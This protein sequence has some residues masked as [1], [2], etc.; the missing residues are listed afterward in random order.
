MTMKETFRQQLADAIG[1]KYIDRIVKQVVETPSCFANLYAL[2]KDEDETTAW[3]A[4]WACEKLS[5]CCPGLFIAPEDLRGEL[6]LRARSCLHGGI[7]RLLLNL[8][9]HLPVSVPIDVPFLN[10]CLGNMLSPSETPAGQAAS[11]KLAYA[12][13]SK[14]PELLEELRLCLENMEPE[15]YTAAV[16]CARNNVLKKL[17]KHIGSPSRETIT[18]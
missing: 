7:R 13:C 11:I 5:I 4:A 9:L 12:L 6:M 15:Y 3:H 1:R 8:L 14:E 10:F 17:R 2:T 18:L 16:Q